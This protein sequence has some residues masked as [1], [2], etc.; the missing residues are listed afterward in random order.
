[1]EEASLASLAVLAA[2]RASA[3]FCLAA[4]LGSSCVA[5]GVGGWGYGACDCWGGVG[6]WCLVW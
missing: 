2:A 5:G 6:W 1:M 3:A 4:S